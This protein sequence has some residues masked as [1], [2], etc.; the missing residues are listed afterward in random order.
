[1]QSEQ[2]VSQEEDELLEIFRQLPPKQQSIFLEQA[3]VTL[4]VISEIGWGYFSQL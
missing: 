2:S 1:M 4:M 3:R